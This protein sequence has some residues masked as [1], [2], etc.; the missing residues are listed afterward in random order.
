MNILRGVKTVKRWKI[1]W[2]GTVYG[3]S[4][5]NAPTEEEAREIADNADDEDFQ[6]IDDDTSWSIDDV[7]EVDENGNEIE[8]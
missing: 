5:A 8:Y 6:H 7:V 4:F 3:E 2:C 1:N